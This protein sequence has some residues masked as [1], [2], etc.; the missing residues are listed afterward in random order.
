MEWAKKDGKGQCQCQCQCRAGARWS[1]P[2]RGGDLLTGDIEKNI[3]QRWPVAAMAQAKALHTFDRSDSA[4][5][6]VAV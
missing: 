6:S 3:D 5:P 1:K 2:N 4:Y